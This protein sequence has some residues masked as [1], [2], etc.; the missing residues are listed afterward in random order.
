MRDEGFRMRDSG[1]AMRDERFDL[2]KWRNWQTHQLEGLEMA[3]A[4]NISN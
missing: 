3:S 4:T 1:S 2:R